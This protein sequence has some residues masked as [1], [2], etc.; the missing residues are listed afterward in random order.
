M[1]KNVEPKLQNSP[2]K[3]QEHDYP[4]VEPID[5]FYH[6]IP[7]AKRIDQFD[8]KQ[9]LEE[10]V[11]NSQVYLHS[12]CAA[13]TSIWHD[14]LRAEAK[15]MALHTYNKHGM[16]SATIVFECS[17]YLLLLDTKDNE[18]MDYN[19]I[20]HASNYWVCDGIL[21][22]YQEEKR[23]EI[24]G[25][26][27]Q[28]MQLQ[29]HSST[30][31][32]SLHAKLQ[33]PEYTKRWVSSVIDSDGGSEGVP[34]VNQDTSSFFLAFRTEP[35]H[36]IAPLSNNMF[37]HSQKL[38][39][40]KLCNCTFSFNSPPF[41]FCRS[42]RFLGLSNCKDFQIQENGEEQF[43][44]ELEFFDSLWVLDICSMDWDLTL[45]ERIVQ[46]M[47]RNMMEVNINR[48]RIWSSNLPWSWGQLGNIRKLRIIEHTHPWEISRLVSIT[49]VFKLELLDLSGN[50]RL[51]FL[52]GLSGAATLNT[53]VLDGCVRLKHVGPADLPPSIVTFSLDAGSG[54]N[55]KKPK[56]SRISMA[57]CKKLRNFRL[58][59]FLPNLEELDLSD[60]SMETLDLT[61]EV[62][63]VP[64]LRR[65]I[66]L[67]CEHLR[68]VAWPK[69]GMPELMFLNIDIPGGQEFRETTHGTL[70]RE[71]SSEG[72]CLARVAIVDIRSLQLFVLR[73]AN[74]FCWN[75]S[76]FQLILCLTSAIKDNGRNYHAKKTGQYTGRQLVGSSLHRSLIPMTQVSYSDVSMDKININL[77]AIT[78]PQHEPEDIHMEIGEGISDINVT[79]AHMVSVVIFFMNRVK[80]LHVHDN[81][82]I[83]TITLM[84]LTAEGKG[85]TWSDLKRFQISR[86]PKVDTVF[87]T[88][89]ATICFETLE[90]FSAYDLMMARC[91]WSRGEMNATTNNASF[92][93]L[94]SMHLYSCP[95]LVFVLPLSWAASGSHLPSLEILHIVCCGE[96][97]QIFPVEANA[98]TKISTGNP[99]GVPNFPNLKHIHLDDLP[100]LHTICE[101]SR[102]FAPELET[103]RVRGCWGLKRIPATHGSRPVV[104]DCEKDWWEKLEW[105]GLEVG[106]HCSLFELHHSK[107]YRKALPRGSVLW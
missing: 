23:W 93:K 92:A 80:S 64:H 29:S 13:S 79:S 74:Q 20:N 53:L 25:A 43:A 51:R 55:N 101:A 57:G 17:L 103:V 6:L 28:Q 34:T 7:K 89:Y 37:I 87:H 42:L 44:Q 95:R 66:L 52:P 72:C 69:T 81:A 60:T 58:R 77:D 82:S 11:D 16:T 85:I 54:K 56:I 19:W 76:S 4:W 40:L 5:E 90:E 50:K 65:V 107:Y 59:G 106:H 3:E 2:V 31:L 48:G 61:D 75:T 39:V 47:S 26:V 62:V 14:L 86:C 38:S 41:R 22:E 24:A 35:H 30:G 84:V 78:E 83:A 104:V 96:L 27:K 10:S 91:I 12:S 49:Y 100:K 88:N 94:R 70:V 21:R 68:G 63:Q 67:G 33:T 15:E 98:L 71:K 9:Q 105:D 46:R 102:M 45:S 97:V 73:G 32:L 1:K 8:V 99:S 36:R 18:I